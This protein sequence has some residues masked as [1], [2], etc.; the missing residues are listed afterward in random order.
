MGIFV[1]SSNMTKALISKAFKWLL[2]L[3]LNQ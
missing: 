2:R 1:D 3:G